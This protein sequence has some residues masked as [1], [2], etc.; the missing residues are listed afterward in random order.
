MI[1]RRE[2]RASGR[3]F[4]L[5]FETRGVY[6]PPCRYL[7]SR[8]VSEGGTAALGRIFLGPVHS[9]FTAPLDYWTMTDYE[10]EWRRAGERLVGGDRRI[11]LF[12]TSYRGPG[13]V[14]H[15]VWLAE[16]DGELVRFQSVIVAA[17][18]FEAYLQATWTTEVDRRWQALFGSPRGPWVV[19]VPDIRDFLSHGPSG[20][21]NVPA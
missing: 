19:A 7:L 21:I 5:R 1:R 3:A 9:P 11:A 8:E 16:R 2:G 18:R 10:R 14:N 20:G 12:P 17:R 4:E 15:S 13:A 6:Y